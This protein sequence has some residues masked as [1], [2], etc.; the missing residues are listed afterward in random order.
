MLIAF[1]PRPHSYSIPFNTTQSW[2]ASSAF[3]VGAYVKYKRASK[4]DPSTYGSCLCS[5]A[6]QFI[7]LAPYYPSCIFSFSQW[8]LNMPTSLSYKENFTPAL[9]PQLLLC[10]SPALHSQTSKTCLHTLISSS[11]LPVTLHPL[12]YNFYP[13]NPTK[14]YP[15]RSPMFPF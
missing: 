9:F 4:T 13:L 11:H 8:L 15:P 14:E 7:L 2:C 12:Q 3:F 6:H 10:L 5:S 1:F